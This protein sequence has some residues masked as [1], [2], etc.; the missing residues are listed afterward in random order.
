M[1]Q[2]NITTIDYSDPLIIATN[3][4]NPMYVGNNLHPTERSMD[5]TH[6][7]QQTHLC[8]YIPSEKDFIRPH[9]SRIERSFKPNGVYFKISP[10]DV[11]RV[12][13]MIEQAFQY[14]KLLLPIYQASIIS[15][16]SRLKLYLCFE[17]ALEKFHLSKKEKS[18]LPS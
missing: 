4:K 18:H 15:T 13:S 3:P 12:K 16:N 8:G 1:G 14:N 11:P 10:A 6:E 17:K 9:E 7:R 5:I 2:L